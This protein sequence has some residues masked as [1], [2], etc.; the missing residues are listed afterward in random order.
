MAFDWNPDVPVMGS[1]QPHYHYG[2][3]GQLQLG[4]AFAD[5]YFREIG[6]PL[7]VADRRFKDSLTVATKAR[8]RLFVLAGQRNMEGEDSYVSAI[9][10]VPGFESLAKDH[11]Q[12]LYRYS[13]GGGVKASTDWEPLGPID[14]LDNFGPELSFGARLRKSIDAHEGIAFVKFTHS[15]AHGPD[16]FPKG[17]PEAHRNLYPKL[18]A[19]IQAAR[20]DL[21]RRGY[22]CHIEGI[23]WH[24]GENDTFFGP[25][26]QNNAK[27]TKQLID[28]LRVDLQQLRIS[29][30]S[31]SP[32]RCLTK[33]T[34]SNPS[35]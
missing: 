19:S 15:G 20:D 31:A 25:Y 16:W 13:L 26:A 28:Q 6:Q 10:D 34:S 29:R 7:A 22:D 3:Q 24:S 21:V 23:Y 32:V 14:Y 18:L 33:S 11:D 5:V 30:S 4:E 35:Y 17:S 9:P 27:W 2:T 12:V 8:V 1:G